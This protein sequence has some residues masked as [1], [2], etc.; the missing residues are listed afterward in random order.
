[1]RIIAVLVLTFSLAAGPAMTV[2]TG[3]HVNAPL[4][5]GLTWNNII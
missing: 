5:K 4:D 3:P 1:M 2:G